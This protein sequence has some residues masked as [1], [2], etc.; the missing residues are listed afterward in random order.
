MGRSLD[1]FITC[2]KPRLDY[3]M[4]KAYQGFSNLFFPLREL[5]SF[6]EIYLILSIDLERDVY[7]YKTGSKSGLMVGLPY[8]LDLFSEHGIKGKACWLVEYNC[9]DGLAFCNPACKLFVPDYEDYFQELKRGGYEF[10]L[11]P[12]V[13]SFEQGQWNYETPLRDPLFV[14][15]VIH[16]GSESLRKVCKEQPVGCRTSA[17]QFASFLSK[18]LETEG[19]LIDCSYR[20]GLFDSI[21]APNAWFADEEDYRFDE[22]SGSKTKVLEVPTTDHVRAAW[23]GLFSLKYKPLLIRPHPTSDILFLSAFFHSWD[24]VTPL[25]ERDIKFKNALDNFLNFAMDDYKVKVVSFA[26]AYEVFVRSTK[27][28]DIN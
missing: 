6:K 2:V 28:Q 14:R 22:T 16:E 9:R 19:Y 17:F 24:A 1:R 12:A 5:P 27:Q 4:L 20:R 11:H 25:G 10:G 7:V 15:K 3:F 23:N 21:T 8:I 26:E 13:C 18:A